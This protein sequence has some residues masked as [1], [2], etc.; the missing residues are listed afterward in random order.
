M[1]SLAPRECA[2]FIDGDYLA[3]PTGP[4]LEVLNPASEEL[5]AIVREADAAEVDKAVAAAR[6]AFDHGPWPT[7]SVAKRQEMLL[8]I[9]DIVAA[10]INELSELECRNTGLPIRQLRGFQVPRAAQNFRFFAEFIGQSAEEVYRQEDGYLTLVTRDPKGVAALIGPWNA[11][12]ALSSM[13]V[14]ACIAF[15]NTCVL[16]PSEQTPLA[17]AR[18]MELMTEAGLPDGV[19]NVVNGRGAVTGRAMV[20]HPDVDVVSFTG[21]TET[22]RAIMASA[23]KGPKAIAMELGGKSANI[24]FADA[25]YDRALDGALAAIYAGNGEM[26]LAGSRILVQRGIA[27]RFIA[28]FVDRA[29]RIGIGDPMDMATELGPIITRR[30]MDRVLS[31]VDIARDEGCE[32]LVG[33]RRGAAFN[34]GYYIEPTAVLAP[35]NATRVCQEEIF[36]PFATFQIF[37]TAEEAFGIANDSVFGL[38]SYVWTSDLNLALRASKTI[39]AGTVWINT[40]LMRDLRSAFGGYRQS[41]IGREGGKGCQALY[42]EEKSTIIAMGNTHIARFGAGK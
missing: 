40:T 20:E 16:K 38:V 26:C 15:G 36:G 5:A 28:D 27:D 37:D 11:P 21:G 39:R 1:N 13:K 18:L 10:H 41:G 8:R 3:S 6:R 24:V 33:G 32:L 35:S 34:K 14:A 4:E 30:H 31:Y 12:L 25:D 9:H 23:A 19:V 7:L 2:S 42:T 29:A 17:I 22:G